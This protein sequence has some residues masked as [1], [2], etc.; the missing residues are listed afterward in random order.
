MIKLLLLLCV[1]S[2]TWAAKEEVAGKDNHNFK[3]GERSKEQELAADAY[4]GGAEKSE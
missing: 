3:D 2:A 1:L 4:K